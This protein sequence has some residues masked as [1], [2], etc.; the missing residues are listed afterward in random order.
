MARAVVL[1]GHGS[2]ISPNTAAVVWQVADALRGLGVAD[3]IAAGFWKEQP[4]FGRVL[5]T[6]AAS[7]AILL[8]MFT[9][10]GYF[11]RQVIPH[12]IAPLPAGLSV[13]TTRALGEHPRIGDIV[14]QRARDAI[15][16]HGLAAES[17][18]LAVIGH[19]TRNNPTS[20]AATEAQ[21]EAL[22]ALGIAREVAAVYLDDDPD[23]PTVYDTTSA[24]V[25][26]AIP[27]FLALGSHTAIDVPEALGLPDGQTEAEVNGRRVI[28]A[29]P[30]AADGGLLDIVLS[31]LAEVGLTPDSVPVGSAW[32]GMP[33]SGREA[34]SALLAQEGVLTVGGLT[35][36]RDAVWAGDA[37]QRVLD[38]PSA[39]RDAVR[40][41]PFRPL[42]TRADLPTGWRVPVRDAHEAHAVVETVYPGLVTEWMAERA[43]ALVPVGV[44][45]VAARQQGMFRPL[46]DL[47]SEGEAALIEEICGGCALSPR[48]GRTRASTGGLPCAEPCN[49][50][51]SAAKE[52]MTNA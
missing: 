52:G 25:L 29:P 15:A 28:Y 3:E 51:L 4:G 17:V 10:Q 8:P 49:V 39:V 38:T 22:R 19:G 21:A 34:F 20:R 13:R 18:A 46:A 1:L 33:A 24:P 7:E 2:H 30:I 41:A 35:V 32:D 48:W 43:G 37:P 42:A 23:I 27:Y 47:P 11:T 50:W 9:A 14:R 16:A 12:E 36:T 5:H 45:G 31:L 40:L 26:V 44:Q 6:V